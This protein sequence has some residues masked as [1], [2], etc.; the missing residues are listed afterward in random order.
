[1][2]LLYQSPKPRVVL[3]ILKRVKKMI[4]MTLLP[5]SQKMLQ[6]IKVTKIRRR[7]C[8]IFQVLG[9]QTETKIREFT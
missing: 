8:L 7:Q 2:K 4:L 5:P 1:M 6:R 3:P 9:I